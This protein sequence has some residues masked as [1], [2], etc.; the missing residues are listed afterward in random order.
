MT[1]RRSAPPRSPRRAASPSA[2]PLA[3]AAALRRSDCSLARPRDPLLREHH[4]HDAPRRCRLSRPTARRSPPLAAFCAPCSPR[5]R[6]FANGAPP[7]MLRQR[8]AP[9]AALGRAAL[10]MG[11]TCHGVRVLAARTADISARAHGDGLD[12]RAAVGLLRRD[13]GG[14]LAD[15]GPASSARGRRAAIRSLADEPEA[16]LG[17]RQG[18]SLLGVTEFMNPSA[19]W[20]SWRRSR[21]LG[22]GKMRGRPSSAASAVLQPAMPASRENLGAMPPRGLG[23]A[24][25]STS[26]GRRRQRLRWRRPR[27]RRAAASSSSAGGGGRGRARGDASELAHR[28]DGDR[29]CVRGGSSRAGSGAASSSIATRGVRPAAVSRSAAPALAAC[30]GAGCG[31]PAVVARGAHA[32]SADIASPPRARAFSRASGLAS[33]ARRA[34]RSARR[35]GAAATVAARR[36]AAPSAGGVASAR[37]PPRARAPAGRRLAPA[38]R[39]LTRSS[40][41]ASTSRLEASSARHK[42]RHAATRGACLRLHCSHVVGATLPAADAAARPDA[43]GWLRRSPASTM[44][45]ARGPIGHDGRDGCDRSWNEGLV[46]RLASRLRRQPIVRGDRRVSSAR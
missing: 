19:P 18:S 27:A 7:A 10:R 13:V 30:R 40:D 45:R 4:P 36:A 24:R 23:T 11:V 17:G 14:E 12:Q 3:A 1:P 38:H 8:P 43:A 34:R 9:D 46:T 22:R 16:R 28:C 21:S 20:E 41:R 29:P 5:A 42:R 37:S 35:R 2:P 6:P 33:A 44:P 32:S 39:Q 31:G 25:C 15:E 26:C